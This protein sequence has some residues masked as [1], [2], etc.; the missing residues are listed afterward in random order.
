MPIFDSVFLLY[1]IEQ[2]SPVIFY[3]V[4]GLLD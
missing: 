3:K 4:P 2:E 1:Y